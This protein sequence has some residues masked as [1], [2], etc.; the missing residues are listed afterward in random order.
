MNLSVGVTWSSLSSLTEV[1]ACIIGPYPPQ[2]AYRDFWWVFSPGCQWLP[3][4]FIYL[5][6]NAIWEL[7]HILRNKQCRMCIPSLLFN[8]IL[9]P[10]A[11]VALRVKKFRLCFSSSMAA[12]LTAQ[13]SRRTLRR[14]D[15][16]WPYTNGYP[17]EPPFGRWTQSGKYNWH[18][19]ARKGH[20]S[21]IF[22]MRL[23]F[24]KQIYMHS[25][26]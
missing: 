8:W 15:P 13:C 20:L 4:W 16:S 5:L 18:W 22:P 19:S 25:K 26:K 14:H 11:L 9:A 3:I 6:E 7:I 23:Y 2:S 10:Q 21:N 12:M 24:L 1:L 17:L